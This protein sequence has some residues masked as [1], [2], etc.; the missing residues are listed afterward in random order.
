VGLVNKKRTVKEKKNLEGKEAF[1]GAPQRCTDLTMVLSSTPTGFSL[2]F[3]GSLLL[4]HSLV[5]SFHRL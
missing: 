4:E 2:S 3:L 5:P 1:G